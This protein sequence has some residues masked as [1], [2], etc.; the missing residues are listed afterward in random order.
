MMKAKQLLSPPEGL[1]DQG[2]SF[3]RWAV[4]AYELES[5]HLEILTQ[6]AICLDRVADAMAAIERDGLLIQGRFGLVENPAAATERNYMKLFRSHVRE[7]GLDADSP[8]E[9]YSRP[10]RLALSARRV[11]G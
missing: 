6:A 3:W 7:L 9:A 5:H 1:G 10:P 4:G 2:R 8:A 11:G